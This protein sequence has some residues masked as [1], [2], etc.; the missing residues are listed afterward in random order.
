[1]KLRDFENPELTGINRL[2]GRAYYYPY[3]DVESALSYDRGV[4]DRYYSLNGVWDILYFDN[5][6]LINDEV[7]EEISS[8]L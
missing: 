1:M 3:R 4:S 7:M 6:E 2:P 5:P 8:L